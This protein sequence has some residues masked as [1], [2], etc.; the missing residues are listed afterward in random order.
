MENEVVQQK[1]ITDEI[2]KKPKKVIVKTIRRPKADKP[3][4]EEIVEE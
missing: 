1:I 4:E 2:T 3:D